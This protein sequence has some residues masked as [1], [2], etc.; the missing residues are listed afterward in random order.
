[1]YYEV[2]IGSLKKRANFVHEDNI[3]NFIMKHGKTTPMY[4]SVFLYEEEDANKLAEKGSVSNH[5]SNRIARWIPIDIDKGD[6]T[7]DYTLQK[8]RDIF[9]MFIYTEDLTEDNI[10]IWFS[11][12]KYE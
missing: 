2:C 6:N 5:I 8:T 4:K 3:Y 1:M 11:A 7:D 9:N 12:V 10:L